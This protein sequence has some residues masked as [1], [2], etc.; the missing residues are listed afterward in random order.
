ML[1]YYSICVS[2]RNSDK[3]EWYGTVLTQQLAK[4]LLFSN[5][6]ISYNTFVQSIRESDKSLPLTHINK[7]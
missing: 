2:I 5:A 6:L 4:N 3:E 1:I 7:M